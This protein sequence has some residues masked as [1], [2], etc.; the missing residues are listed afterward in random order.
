MKPNIQLCVVLKLRMNGRGIV[1]LKLCCFMVCTGT[2]LPFTVVGGLCV[3]QYS[4]K[5]K[6]C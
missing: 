1:S 3:T 4:F 6:V 2:I 5:Y